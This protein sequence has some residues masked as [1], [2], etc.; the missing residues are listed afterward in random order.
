MKFKK[1]KGELTTS[2]STRTQDQNL[3]IIKNTENQLSL[4][5][6]EVITIFNYVKDAKMER[7]KNIN[8][9]YR[10]WKSK[11]HEFIDHET[12]LAQ[13][14]NMLVAHAAPPNRTKT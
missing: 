9:S 5:A 8:E 13:K 10:K 11:V 4:L 12:I 1:I 14:R 3:N 2:S 6:N 7:R